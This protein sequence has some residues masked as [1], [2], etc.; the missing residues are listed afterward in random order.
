MQEETSGVRGA[1]RFRCS[2]A[3]SSEHSDAFSGIRPRKRR[4]TRRRRCAGASSRARIPSERAASRDPSRPPDM[5]STTTTSRCLPSTRV[6]PWARGR[7]P[8]CPRRRHARARDRRRR[9]RRDIRSQLSGVRRRGPA[10]DRATPTRCSP[11]GQ[12]GRRTPSKSVADQIVRRLALW[13]GSTVFGYPGDGL[14]GMVPM[15]VHRRI[16]APGTLTSHGHG[17]PD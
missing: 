15:S 7:R 2:R 6:C 9:D 14:N 16:A 8:R 10:V 5:G 13:G 1:E 17:T 12:D 3:G 11:Q 4:G